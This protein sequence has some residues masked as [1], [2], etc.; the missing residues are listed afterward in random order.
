LVR[1]NHSNWIRFGSKETL[2]FSSDDARFTSKADIDAVNK[3]AIRAERRP[4][5]EAPSG[6]KVQRL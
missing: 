1:Q 6:L 5:K 4:A 3:I 2:T